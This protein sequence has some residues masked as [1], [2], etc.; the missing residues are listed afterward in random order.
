MYLTDSEIVERFGGRRP[1]LDLIAIED[2]AIPVS[3]L[4]VHVLAHE[5]KELPL[6][7]EFLLRSIRAG[8][9]LVADIASLLG[10]DPSILDGSVVSQLAIGNVTYSQ[11]TRSVR[12]TARGEVAAVEHSSIVPVEQEIPV[13]FDRTIWRAVD[14]RSQD[15]IKKWEAEQAG[16]VILP[17]KRSATIRTDDVRAKEVEAF[18]SAGHGESRFQILEITRVRRSKNLYLPAKLLVFSDGQ[19]G[20]P[21]LMLLVDGDDSVYHENEL[22]SMGGALKLGLR[23]APSAEPSQYA[24]ISQEVDAAVSH[25]LTATP[26]SGHGPIVKQVGVYEHAVILSDALSSA[27]QRLLI[28]SPWI[29]R[30]VVTTSFLADLERRLRAGVSVAI[31]HGYGPDDSGSDEDAIRKLRN[32]ANRFPEKFEFVRLPNTHAKILIQDDVYV[33]TS[34]NWLSFRGDPERTYRMEE[35]TMVTSREFADQNH[36]RYLEELRRV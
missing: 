36:A 11:S 13:A 14:Y 1:G 24:E 27:R 6:L 33:T 2:A 3:T 5:E 31:G 30:A 29:R 17:A 16:M 26:A 21:E 28:I 34:F 22:A 12:L 35:G 18:V 15:L 10:I 19:S 4:G 23:V 20:N 32:L 25:Q 8:L 7:D 9:T